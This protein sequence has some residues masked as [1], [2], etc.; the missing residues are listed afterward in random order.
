MANTSK[1]N[2]IYMIMGAIFLLVAIQNI[3]IGFNPRI[4]YLDY[5]G[6]EIRITNGFRLMCILGGVFFT[7]VVI[8]MMVLMIREKLAKNKAHRVSQQK[9][10]NTCKVSPELQEKIEKSKSMS[11]DELEHLSDKE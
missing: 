7:V 3:M 2:K 8:S 4:T 9:W 11:L 1:T 10:D 5:F 6:Y